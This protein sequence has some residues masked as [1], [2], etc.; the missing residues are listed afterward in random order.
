[1][2]AAD[3]TIETQPVPSCP[4]CSSPG[5]ILYNHIP[6]RLFG[7][8]GT[9]RL[10][11]CTRTSCQLVWLDPAPQTSELPKVYQQYYTHVDTSTIHATPG[12]WYES[13]REAYLARHLSYTS[14]QPPLWARLLSPLLYLYPAGAEYA[15]ST[16]LFLPHPAA[17]ARLLDVGCG[18]GRFLAYMAQH[19]W[20]AEGCDF[21][22]NAVMLAQQRGL[23]VREGALEDIHYDNESFDVVT[24]SHLIEH[25][26]DVRSLLREA[27]RILKPG[28]KLVII[29]P[30]TQSFGHRLFGQDWRGLEVPRHVQIFNTMNIATLLK[31][32]GFTN[33]QVRT[34]TRGSRYILSMSAALRHARR[35]GQDGAL[36]FTVTESRPLRLLR[37]YGARAAAAVL[38]SSGE[39]LFVVATS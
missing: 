19:G 24:M 9:W 31:E 34:L 28:G 8:P 11:R 17:G 4:L 32:V 25:V 13:L 18:D 12:R 10:R 6:D 2:P 37:Q 38:K 7:V 23:T 29:T 20:I 26:Y 30:N 21:D 36:G 5:S 1:M 14:L 22:A 33:L 16:V 3:V 15:A 27:R 39:E 35:S